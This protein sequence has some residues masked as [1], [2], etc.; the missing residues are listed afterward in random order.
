MAAPRRSGLLSKDTSTELVRKAPKA[1][2]TM[3]FVTFLGY[4]L[5]LEDKDL[6]L[7]TPH[8]LVVR[9]RESKLK[10]SWEVPPSSLSNARR[11]SAGS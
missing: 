6:L 10:L 8:T 5:E 9:Y 1:P 2:K 3:C 4:P 11:C 7:K